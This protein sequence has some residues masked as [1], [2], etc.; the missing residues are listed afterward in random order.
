MLQNLKILKNLKCLRIYFEAIKM[1]ENFIKCSRISENVEEFP[2]NVAKFR[3]FI[4]FFT[5]KARKCVKIGQNMA[6]FGR[7]VAKLA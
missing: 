4:T 1:F 7:N 6:F 5:E 2:I 3:E